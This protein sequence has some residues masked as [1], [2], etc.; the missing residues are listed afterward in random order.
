LLPLAAA[1]VVGAPAPFAK[2][3]RDRRDDLSK[4]Q[5]RWQNTDAFVWQDT[6]WGK[7]NPVTLVVIKRDR[8]EWYNGSTLALTETI[9]LHAGAT[10]KGSTSRP[11]APVRS[12]RASMRSKAT[13]SRLWLPNEENNARLWIG[14]S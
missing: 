8:I 2:P 14:G 4:L 13:S 3:T 6:G 10:P 1:P 12:I 5:A 7:I 9:T 11:V